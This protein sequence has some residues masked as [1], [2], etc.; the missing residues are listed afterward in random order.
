MKNTFKKEIDRQIKL[1]KTTGKDIDTIISAVSQWSESSF[2]CGFT[3]FQKNFLD[4]ARHEIMEDAASGILPDPLERKSDYCKTI[5]ALQAGMATPLKISF[6]PDTPY[7]PLE[8]SSLGEGSTMVDVYV[9]ADQAVAD[10]NKVFP[11]VK[12]LALNRALKGKI[13]KEFQPGP[14]AYVTRFT[15]RGRLKDLKKDAEFVRH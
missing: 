2:F 1:V 13:I 7:Y 14:W 4:G 9:I 11:E 5:A 8:I 12:S 6:Q 10:L 15:W 3:D